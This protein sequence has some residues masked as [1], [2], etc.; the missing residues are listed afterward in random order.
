[1]G[2]L[3]PPQKELRGSKWRMDGWQLPLLPQS[4]SQLPS[5]GNRASRASEGGRS[6][7]VQQYTGR[8][9]VSA[10]KTWIEWSGQCTTASQ[11][12][13]GCDSLAWSIRSPAWLRSCAGEQ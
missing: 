4:T 1:M 3:I 7:T 8:A 6:S 13:T 12:A 10:F 2:L 11:T 9:G 5:V